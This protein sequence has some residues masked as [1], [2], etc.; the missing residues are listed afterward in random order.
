LT[1]DSGLSTVSRLAL[2][3]SAI[4]TS[5]LVNEVLLIERLA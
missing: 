5:V 1:S 4:N 2:G 3:F